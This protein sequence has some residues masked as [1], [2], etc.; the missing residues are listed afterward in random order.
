MLR[1]LAKALFRPLWAPTAPRP[2]QTSAPSYQEMVRNEL[3]RFAAVTDVHALPAIYMYWAGKHLDPMFRECGFADVDEFYT[4]HLFEAARRT[5]IPTRFISIGAG[6]CDTEVRI[7]RK[8][9][10]MDLGAFTFECVELNPAMLERGR[11]DASASGLEGNFTFTEA[12]FNEWTPAGQYTA[13]MA[14]HSL[15]HVVN[16]EGLFDSIKG[17]LHPAGY[18][19]TNDMIGRNGHQR[20]PEALKHVDE[21]WKEIPDAYRYNQ[22]MQRH[23]P[24]FINWDCSGEGFE[25]VRA[26]D[27]LPLL[28]ERFDF[29]VFLGFANVINPF[30]DRC[31]GHN[32]DATSPVDQALI[33]RIHAI[34]E[35]GFAS[36]ELKPTQMLAVMSP[37]P[38]VTHVHARG[39]SPEMSVRRP[40]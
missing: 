2:V 4:K 14:N 11:L 29:P 17:A 7:A 36:G 21:I 23:E 39:L 27:I 33:D 34:D 9:R 16:L 22:L 6:N 28:L 1:N 10:D 13:V 31:F 18:F 24:T 40:D 12:D 25:G 37:V 32:F 26:Q 19:L 35:S 30:I 8:L 3:E 15:H 5:G 38:S 20:W